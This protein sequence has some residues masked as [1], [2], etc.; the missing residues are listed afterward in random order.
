MRFEYAHELAG[1]GRVTVG[2]TTDLAG[3]S[4]LSDLG[5]PTYGDVLPIL[6]DAGKK[7]EASVLALA[8]T[9]DRDTAPSRL[10]GEGD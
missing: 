6:V 9:N 10:F 3:H 5:G 8:S 2:I 4:R 7:F 1:G